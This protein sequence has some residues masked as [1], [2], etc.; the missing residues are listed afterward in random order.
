M[1]HLVRGLQPDSGG[2]DVERA[3]PHDEPL[4]LGLRQNDEAA[5]LRP[6]A[7]MGLT[8]RAPQ[9]R[10]AGCRPRDIGITEC[11]LKRRDTALAS[12]TT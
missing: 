2:D 1:P 9:W 6:H 8:A 12:G 7:A 3:V 10:N 4:V 11:S 5:A